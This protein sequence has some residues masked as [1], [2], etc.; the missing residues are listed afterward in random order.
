MMRKVHKIAGVLLVVVLLA[1]AGCGQRYVPRPRGYFRID[2]PDT[3]YSLYA[4]KGFPYA[5]E[6]SDNAEVQPRMAEG[7]RYW[8]DIRYPRF[9]AAVHC[10]YKPVEG[11]LRALSADAQ[12]FVFK[13]ASVASS[14]PEQGYENPETRVYGVYYE[15]QGNTA[16]PCQFYLTDSVRHFFRGAVYFN[17]SPNQD[18]LAPVIDYIEQDVRHMIETFN[19][20]KP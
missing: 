15:L 8:I 20:Q 5:F 19:W 18:S 17:N 10:S 7:E 1:M 14:L 16:S 13:H 9:N 4:P 2:L 11:N 3:A 12:N 6:L